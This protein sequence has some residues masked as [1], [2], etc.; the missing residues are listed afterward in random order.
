MIQS[1][2][3]VGSTRGL[4]RVGLGR[5]GKIYGFRGLGWV[6]LYAGWV[7]LGRDLGGLGWVGSLCATSLKNSRSLII[8]LFI[9]FSSQTLICSHFF[10][11][12]IHKCLLNWAN[13]YVSR[14]HS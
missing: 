7:G 5:V 13:D 2:P 6:E 3:R 1:C 10:C 9:I 14:R 8:M 12:T 11:E 4:G